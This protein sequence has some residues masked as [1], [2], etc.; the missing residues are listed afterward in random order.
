MKV[1]GESGRMSIHLKNVMFWQFYF[2]YSHQ[3]AL[4]PVISQSKIQ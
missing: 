2:I 3:N 1:G 4:L